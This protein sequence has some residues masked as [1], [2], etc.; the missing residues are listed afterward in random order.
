MKKNKIL[1]I[2][3]VGL[4]N[5]G[6]LPAQIIPTWATT[7]TINNPGS[8]NE[9]DMV[10]DKSGNVYI[11]GFTQDTVDSKYKIVTLK[12]NTYGQFQ[13]IQEIDSLNYYTKIAIDDSGNV[14]ITGFSDHNLITVKYNSQGILKWVKPYSSVGYNWT[15]D[16][17]TDDS[18]NVY[19]T[20]LSVGGMFTTIKYNSSGN[21]M[22]AALE[23]GANG[24]ANSYIALDD[25]RNVYIAFRG[26]D[27]N[28]TCNTIKYN[29]SGIKQWEQIYK[30]NFI[31]GL[32]MPRGLKFDTNGFI[33]M[34]AYTS[35]YTDG[36]YAVVKYDTI[37]NQIWASSYS[38]TSYGD[39]SKAMTI[40]KSGNVYVTGV[41]YQTGGTIDS[42][43]TIKFNKYGSFKWAKT[44]SLGYY[45]LDEPSAIATDTLGNI[46]VTGES[47]D[48]LNHENFATIKY[49]SLGNEI[50]VARYNNTLNSVDMA[51][52]ISLDI[53]GNIYASGTNYDLNCSSILT[54][55]YSKDVGL[56]ELSTASECIVNIYPNPFK[57]SFTLMTNVDLKN[58]ELIIYD[59]FGR[60]ILKINK[61]NNR[62]VTIQRN[63]IADGIYF[64]RLVDKNKIIAKG[65][66]IAN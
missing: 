66:I 14:Y 2:F 11:T 47:S 39:V 25:N 9:N 4:I 62:I 60:E 64:F 65:K 21:Q 34:C 26:L 44:Y 13:W 46:Y 53:F 30:G 37:G 27:T 59:L 23:I 16:I 54:I 36:D 32:A 63:N 58:A 24:L 7:Y 8:I 55:K 35:D 31:S 56:Q 17:I 20:G 28:W 29:S 6:N 61:I 33:Y 41:I 19:I 15:W 22:W 43:A 12:Y 3:I 45:A 42:I 38:F 1:L 52:S 57:T 18:C 40:D 51:N 49:D 50:W 10:T 48:N 5:C